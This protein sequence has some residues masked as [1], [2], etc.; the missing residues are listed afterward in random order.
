MRSSVPS[1]KT[2][3]WD[4]RILTGSSFLNHKTSGN[5]V[6]SAWKEEPGLKR[7]NYCVCEQ[8][9]LDML[10]EFFSISSQS[11]YVFSQKDQ[12]KTA[13]YLHER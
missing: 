8:D 1:L 3:R 12:Q 5:G 9:I 11:F 4:A 13:H 2:P 6:P 7:I 10:N